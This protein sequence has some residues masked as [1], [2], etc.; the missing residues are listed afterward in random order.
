[1]AQSSRKIAMEF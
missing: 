1:M